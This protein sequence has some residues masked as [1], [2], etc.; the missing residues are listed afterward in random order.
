MG[1]RFALFF[2]WLLASSFAVAELRVAVAI[3]PQKYLLERLAG[4]RVK[5][6]QVVPPG[7]GVETYE[8]T[9]RLMSELDSS[10]LYFQ[11]GLPFERVWLPKV[12]GLHP[13]LQVVDV[14]AGIER[15]QMDG[16]HHGD[17]RQ[18]EALA[19]P[20]LWL[21]PGL[22]LRQAANMR[23][24]LMAADP[25]AAVHYQQGY[26]RLE[27]ELT[28]LDAE[29]S[30]QLASRRGASFM[31]YHPAFG[32]FAD[33]YGLRQIAIEREGKSPGAGS[34]AQVIEAGRQAGVRVILVEQ[35][36]DRRVAEMVA[37][38]LGARVVK[39]DHL[40]EDVP[41]TLRQLGALLADPTP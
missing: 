31:V 38:S 6:L 15:L 34:L 41:A 28:A 19:D 20:H 12:R 8:P 27:Q 14:A 3:A 29:L 22:L 23:D 37:D 18:S 30:A 10:Q 25:A 26:G 35:Q 1:R 9:P 21:A 24:A 5:V 11:L 17:S 40:A 39:V 33:A 7:Q 36:T 4:S 16:H 13:A 32:Y 2:L